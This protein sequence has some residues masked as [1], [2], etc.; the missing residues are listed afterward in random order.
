MFDQRVFRFLQNRHQRVDI[1]IFQRCDHGQTA[2]KFRDQAE[3]QQILRLALGEQFADPA[4]FGSR[5]M[6]TEAD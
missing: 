1:E 3:F 2:D 6:G 4:L 5:N